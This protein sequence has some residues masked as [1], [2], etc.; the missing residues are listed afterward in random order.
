[1]HSLYTNEVT[2]CLKPAGLSLASIHQHIRNNANPCVYSIARSC[3]RSFA[4]FWK[5]TKISFWAFKVRSFI[6]YIEDCPKTL[7]K[8]NWIHLVTC[9]KI[10]SPWPT[11]LQ[12]L[13]ARQN[14]WNLHF[15]SLFTGVVWPKIIF[16]LWQRKKRELEN[17]LTIFETCVLNPFHGQKMQENFFPT[18]SR[19]DRS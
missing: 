2:D 9:S 4:W 7:R 13:R 17:N 11:L 1:M 8:C 5:L 6:F 12:S 16:G 10:E 3:Q 19:E 14:L 15:R 18:G